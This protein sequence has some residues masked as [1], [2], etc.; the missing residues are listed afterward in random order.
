MK[1]TSRASSRLGLCRTLSLFVLV[2]AVSSCGNPLGDIIAGKIEG[3]SDTALA[4]L[5]V[6]LS[7][8]TT[9]DTVS[10][11][12][13]F[14]PEVTEYSVYGDSLV[15]RATITAS[16]DD[17]E[18]KLEWKAGD[19]AWSALNS[20]QASS[21]IAVSTG[22][23]SISLRVNS[24]SGIKS[25][26][27][28]IDVIV[29][30]PGTGSPA[31][32]MPSVVQPTA[33]FGYKVA[34]SDDG[35]TLAVA[36]SQYPCV[37]VYEKSGSTWILAKTL[38]E[39]G[40]VYSDGYGYGLAMTRDGSVVVVGA[41][42]LTNGATGAGKAYVYRR[43]GSSWS[44]CSAAEV[45]EAPFP[46]ANDRFGSSVA[47]SD[48]GATVIIGANGGLVKAG[49]A[50]VFRYESSAW[51]AGVALPKTVN[52]NNDMFG[53]SVAISADGSLAVVGAPV[54]DA[55]GR[56]FFYKYSASAWVEV[57]AWQSTTTSVTNNDFGRAIAI[58]KDGHDVFVGANYATEIAAVSGAVYAFQWDGSSSPTLFKTILPGDVQA[59]EVFGWSVWLSG[60]GNYLA[61]GSIGRSVAGAA[62]AGAAYVFRN[63][64]GS[65]TEIR[66]Y[67]NPHPVENDQF[68]IGVCVSDAASV[69]AIGVAGRNVNGIN[70][71]GLAFVY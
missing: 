46:A 39:T 53:M 66:R 4:S 27:Y 55:P 12:P 9:F 37:Q 45:L 3:V 21:G 58:S 68:G 64:S 5:S 48:D 28:V 1:W 30:A 63:D 70:S 25:R 8:G 69:V 42:W 23:T 59:S 36:G 20:G 22:T 14:S 56:A 24:E 33:R 57:K 35:S 65:W 49:A 11:V 6:S 29:S 10:L 38:I 71:Q 16:L 17:S 7:A 51:S 67:Q 26:T 40:I 54:S 47:I 19:S 34:I 61:A 13:V 62:N 18:A 43:S 41:P 15:G 52:A 32:L 50:F 60:D 44:N 2:L 31:V